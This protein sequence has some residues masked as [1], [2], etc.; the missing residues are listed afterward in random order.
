MLNPS[1]IHRR[2]FRNMDALPHNKSISTISSDIL[3]KTAKPVGAR[4]LSK[5]QDAPVSKEAGAPDVDPKA[6]GAAQKFEAAFISQM[7]NHSGLAEALTGSGGEAVSSFSQFYLENLA[8][9][10]TEDGGFGLAEKI[11]NNIKQKEAGN[12]ELG[13]L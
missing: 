2:Y 11:Y 8:Q 4:D 1:L 7:L 12:G 13:R 3:A 5:A 9:K 10:I 6:W